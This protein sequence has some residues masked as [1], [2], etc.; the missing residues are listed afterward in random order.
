MNKLKNIHPGEIL[1]KEFLL[2]MNIGQNKI[3]KDIGVTP[4]RINE[5]IHE[6]RGVTADTSLR[7]AKYFGV[8]EDFFLNLQKN[9]DLEKSRKKIGNKITNIKAF[10]NY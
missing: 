9:Y 1:Q 2:P 8:S 6:S 7:L 3:A 10:K 4:M 5:I